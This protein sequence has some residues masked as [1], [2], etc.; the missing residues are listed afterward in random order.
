MIGEFDIFYPLQTKIADWYPPPPPPPP[1]PEEEEDED[2]DAQQG[3]RQIN[4]SYSD[5]EFTMKLC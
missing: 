5:T 4:C 2:E 3:K 1:P